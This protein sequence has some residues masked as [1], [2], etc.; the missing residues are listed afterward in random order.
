MDNK[1][2]SY[3]KN[4]ITQQLK[5]NFLSRKLYRFLSI[6]IT[7]ELNDFSKRKIIV[8]NWAVLITLF[9]CT[10]GELFAIPVFLSG[11]IYMGNHATHGLIIAGL[12]TLYLHHK[13]QYRYASILLFYAFVTMVTIID[14]SMLMNHF[15]RYEKIFPFFLVLAR[16]LFSDNEEKIAVFSVFLTTFSLK[17]FN[18]IYTKQAIT[19]EVQTDFIVLLVTLIIIDRFVWLYKRDYLFLMNNYGELEQKRQMIHTQS[20]KLE[21]LSK[22]KSKLFLIVSHDVRNPISKLVSLIDMYQ[23]NFID[24][25]DLEFL[26]PSIDR[27]LGE[28]TLLLDNLLYWSKN[29]LG[30]LKETP[31]LLNLHL[32]V[33]EVLEIFEESIRQKNLIIRN[34]VELEVKVY[35]SHNI[36]SIILRNLISNAVKFCKKSDTIEM[37]C[38]QTNNEYWVI[39][40]DSGVGIEENKLPLLFQGIESSVGTAKEKGSG[41]GLMVCKEFVEQVGGSFRVESQVGLGS[42]F[43]FSIP[44]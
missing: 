10:A 35:Y 21:E 39:V 25:K 42:S 9:L 40:K 5:S 12:L 15:K 2:S 33:S 19:P 37:I 26:V 22:L 32:L 13:H 17:I 43:M 11:K 4:D 20:K 27:N 8:L 7:E 31:K 14:I 23:A 3:K 1:V 34:S 38:M 6:G 41:V 18:L 30:E 36:L 44:K 28:T 29:E 16:F 24:E